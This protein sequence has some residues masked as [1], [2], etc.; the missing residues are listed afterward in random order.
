V[1]GGAIVTLCVVVAAALIT[2]GVGLVIRFWRAYGDVDIPTG[3][4]L[5]LLY[6]GITIYLL[7]SA[8]LTVAGIIIFTH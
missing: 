7:S 6:G 8:P 5:L 1:I 4:V 2:T 3:T